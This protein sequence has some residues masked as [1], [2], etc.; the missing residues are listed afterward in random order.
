[1]K[2]FKSLFAMLLLVGMLAPALW[3]QEAKTNAPSKI[4]ARDAKQYM[5]ARKTVSGK[6]VEVSKAE[7][8]VRLNFEEPFPKQPFTAVIFPSRT[9][10]FPK[11]DELE[12]KTVEVTGEITEV[13]NRPQII[14]NSTNQLRI[15]VPEK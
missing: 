15:V 7:K 1:M 10:L 4:S 3:A 11:L 13:R 6:I 14:L 12:G 8:I 5:G 2:R 9:N